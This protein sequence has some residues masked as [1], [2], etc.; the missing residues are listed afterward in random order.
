ME[1][2]IYSLMFGFVIVIFAGKIGAELLAFRNREK[3]KRLDETKKR[4][5][6]KWQSQ[7]K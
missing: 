4:V 5:D 2:W 3:L 6:T 1:Q 7:M